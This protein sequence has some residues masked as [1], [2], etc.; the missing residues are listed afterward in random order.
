M[1]YM[2]IYQF[3]LEWSHKTSLTVQIIR[4]FDNRSILTHARVFIWF[5]AAGGLLKCIMFW[6]LSKSYYVLNYIVTRVLLFDSV[7]RRTLIINEPNALYSYLMCKYISLC[8][9]DININIIFKSCL[10]Q[11]LSLIELMLYIWKRLRHK[12]YVEI[13]V[14]IPCSNH[15]RGVLLVCEE[16][17]RG[18]IV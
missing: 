7:L 11:R 18:R 4:Y 12:E 9:N 3:T 2:A 14:E 1:S 5:G 15:Q 8:Y 16:R 10:E 13:T 6:L 17:L